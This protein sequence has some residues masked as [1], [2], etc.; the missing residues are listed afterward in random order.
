MVRPCSCWQVLI[1]PKDD[2][3]SKL[4]MEV[5]KGDNRWSSRGPPQVP[6]EVLVDVGP[7][8]VLDLEVQLHVEQD[9]E[10]GCI[11]KVRPA[12]TEGSVNC[13]GLPCLVISG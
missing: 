3:A 9:C 12:P 5:G 8:N 4:W 7:E 11:A 1:L 2:G 6:G 13:T 10:I